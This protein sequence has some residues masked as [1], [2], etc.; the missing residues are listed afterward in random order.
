M[1]TVLKDHSVWEEKFALESESDTEQAKEVTR[2]ESWME[3]KGR[4]R[5]E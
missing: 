3:S 2:T 5:S 1:H 4:G